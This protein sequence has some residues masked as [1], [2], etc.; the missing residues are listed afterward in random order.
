MDCGQLRVFTPYCVFVCIFQGWQRFFCKFLGVHNNLYFFEKNTFSTHYTRVLTKLQ[1]KFFTK[2][3]KVFRENI[4]ENLFF[5]FLT[6]LGIKSKISKKIKKSGVW[7]DLIKIVF[8]SAKKYL[9]KIFF[10]I[11][12]AWNLFGKSVSFEATPRSE[13]GANPRSWLPQDLNSWICKRIQAAEPLSGVLINMS[14]KCALP[15]PQCFHVISAFIIFLF[16]AK[17]ASFI[18]SR[19]IILSS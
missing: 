1:V 11:I 14:N 19:R 6:F 8:K 10:F 3:K 12:P 9:K 13:Y 16:V 18:F 2:K 5:L 7:N 15:L 4:Y 17:I